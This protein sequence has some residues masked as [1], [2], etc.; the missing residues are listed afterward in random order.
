[1]PKQQQ[2]SGTPGKKPPAIGTESY[3]ASFFTLSKKPGLW[4]GRY[5]RDAS[6][7]MNADFACTNPN[8]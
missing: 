3:L 2:P 5:P 4:A 1:M 6:R 8:S 7:G